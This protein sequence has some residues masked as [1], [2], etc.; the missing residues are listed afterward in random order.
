MLKYSPSQG[1]PVFKQL[2][3]S[4]VSAMMALLGSASPA[5][6]ASATASLNGVKQGSGVN[7]IT[8]C[9]F[10]TFRPCSS[11]HLRRSVASRTFS[12]FMILIKLQ[13][14]W[15]MMLCS[16]AYAFINSPISSR[17]ISVFLKMGH[18]LLNFSFKCSL[19]RISTS[20]YPN[21]RS[22]HTSLNIHFG[23]IS[24]TWSSNRRTSVL[25]KCCNSRFIFFKSRH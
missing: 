2:T 11:Y 22:F 20:T 14:G 6:L 3:N 16:S 9:T 8:W 1:F 4:I 7:L 19:T 10:V 21:K 13:Q 12:L 18:I 17:L 15:A 5:L 23:L 25:M 24:L